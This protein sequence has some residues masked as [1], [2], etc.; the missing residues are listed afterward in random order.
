M[1]YIAL[2]GTGTALYDPR[3]AVAKFLE[4]KERRRKLPDQDLYRNQEFIQNIFY[5]NLKL[6]YIFFLNQHVIIIPRGY[7]MNYFNVIILL[8]L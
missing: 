2:N 1:M 8:C 3:S 5:C 4:S 6:Y 7:Q